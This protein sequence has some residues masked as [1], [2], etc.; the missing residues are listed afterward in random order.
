[1]LVRDVMK[2]AVSPRR[3]SVSTARKE[4]PWLVLRETSVAG[5]RNPDPSPALYTI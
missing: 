1:M 3:R 5:P 2:E 4:W